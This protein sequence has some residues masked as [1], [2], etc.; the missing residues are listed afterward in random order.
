MA[1]G[2]GVVLGTSGNSRDWRRVICLTG[3]R[4]AHAHRFTA[5]LTVVAGHRRHALV[6]VR[7]RAM[8]PVQAGPTPHMAASLCLL[9][10]SS[11][12]VSLHTKDRGAAHAHQL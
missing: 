12:T 6:R 5:S 9:A 2:V 10:A 11:S 1:V 4:R 8:Q 7:T 3:F